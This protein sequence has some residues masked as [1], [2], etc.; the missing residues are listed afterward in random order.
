MVSQSISSLTPQNVGQSGLSGGGDRNEYAEMGCPIHL[1]PRAPAWLERRLGPCA[2]GGARNRR[3]KG[4]A[5]K[6]KSRI[7]I[8]K[9]SE[10]RVFEA[11]ILM[12]NIISG[13]P[14]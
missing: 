13:G 5:G 2:F 9:E 3:K 11:R 14:R 8:P 10:E 7:R 6:R 12:G 4:T 1:L